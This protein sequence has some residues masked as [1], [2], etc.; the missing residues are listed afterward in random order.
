MPYIQFTSLR[1]S[2]L[3]INP[4]GVVALDI[5]AIEAHDRLGSSIEGSQLTIRYRNIEQAIIY[6]VT[7]KPAEVLSAFRAAQPG[8]V[9]VLGLV[10]DPSH[11]S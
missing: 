6:R 3:L 4:E 2:A 8:S 5:E 9:D 7:A 10:P 1:N 11:I